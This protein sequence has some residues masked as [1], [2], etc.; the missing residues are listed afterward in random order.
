[1]NRMRNISKA[2][3]RAVALFLATALL[4]ACGHV[5]RQDLPETSTR[6]AEAEALLATLKARTGQGVMF[7][8]HDDTLYGIGW[9]GDEGRSD[10]QSVCGDYPA[11]IS[12]D[13]GHIEHDSLQSLDNARFDKIRREVVNHYLRGGVVSLSWHVDNPKTGGSSWDVTDSTVVRSVLPG[14]ECHTKFVGWLDR[15][16]TFLNSLQTAEGVKVPVLFRPWHEHTG[17]WFWWGQ[18]LCTDQEYKQLW[19]MTQDTLQARGVNHLLYAYSPGSEP[20]DSAQYLARYPG[21]GRIDLVGFDT[22]QFDREAYLQTMQHMIDLTVEVAQA[23]G[24]V[25]AITETGYEG[26][27]DPRWWTETLLPLLQR[28]PL[29]YVLVWRNARER[30]THH[31]APYPGHASADDFVEFYHHP[32]THFAGDLQENKKQ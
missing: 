5:K 32:L 10:V 18:K 12:F 17:S 26:I 7:G 2:A 9:D 8:H 11:V 14:G 25:A 1:M 30:P 13:L 21:D 24:K 3:T 23:H 19:A 27:P 28:Q 20:Q 29:S 6:S 4:G 31:Y 16:A 22:Y 15:L